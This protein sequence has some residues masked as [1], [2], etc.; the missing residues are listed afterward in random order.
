MKNIVN[1]LIVISILLFGSL[2]G[3]ELVLLDLSGSMYGSRGDKA[4]V[5][6]Q[7]LLQKHIRILGYN[8]E[9]HEI[10]N[11]KNIKY[12][13]GSD[14]GKALEYVY[15]SEPNVNFISIITDGDVGNSE[16]VLKYG[17]FM[18][19]HNIVICSVS[20]DTTSIPFEL[21]NISKK[22]FSTTDIL[23]ARELC[24]GTRKTALHEV[25][26]D[27]DENKFNLF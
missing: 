22:S 9:L 10:K 7:Q 12:Q 19:N 26:E 15:F 2:Y 25:I 11:V 24:R 18:K 5:M 14:L 8:N 3:K 23:K 6:V 16:K 27:I 1:K 17:G 20:I 13:N 4:K 21:K